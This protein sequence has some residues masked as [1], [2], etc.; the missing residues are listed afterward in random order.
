MRNGWRFGELI[1]SALLYLFNE[2]K[3]GN[4]KVIASI[5][6]VIVISYIFF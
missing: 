2:I 4:I 5:F 3:K 1:G 6:L